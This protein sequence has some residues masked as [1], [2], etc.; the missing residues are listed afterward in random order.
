MYGGGI[1]FAISALQGYLDIPYNIAA[2]V[3]GSRRLGA[4]GLYLQESA[5]KAA[6]YGGVGYGVL[7]SSGVPYDYC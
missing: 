6:G 7:W 2:T 5:C 3:G 4:G 1:A